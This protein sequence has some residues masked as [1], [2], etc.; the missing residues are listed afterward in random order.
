M[1]SVNRKDTDEYSDVPIP[2]Q[3]LSHTSDVNTGHFH[4]TG[5]RARAGSH[6]SHRTLIRGTTF[7]A[8]LGRR[9][10][11]HRSNSTYDRLADSSRRTASPSSPSARIRSA[12]EVPDL[13]VPLYNDLDDD[14]PSA[15]DFRQGFEDVIGR[16]MAGGGGSWLS[17]RNLNDAVPVQAA[18]VDDDLLV[19]ESVRDG[20]ANEEDT[21]RLADPTNQQAVA[22][23]SPVKERASMQSVRFAPGPSLGD[24]LQTAEEGLSRSMSKGSRKSSA[25]SGTKLSPSRSASV[26]TGRNTLSPGSS[27]VRRVSV[28]VK[29]MSQRVVN[30]SNDPEAV[31]STIRRRTSNRSE[32]GEGGKRQRPQIPSIEIH[33]FDGGGEQKVT[34]P[35]RKESGRSWHET[36]NPLR[37][38]SLR[39]FSPRSRVRLFLC[40]VL[41][42]P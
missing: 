15:I 19:R 6:R 1:A 2:L 24:D 38:N 20:V 21:A 26:R 32:N 7:G 34:T 13:Q 40:D 25:A 39:M 17:P 27:P 37:G 3:D 22:G 35:L 9:L 42:H 10:S 23:F 18:N 12:S 28:A 30:L 41:I 11:L 36:A 31:E 33:P 16:E 8:E 29:N 4:T 14:M 5:A